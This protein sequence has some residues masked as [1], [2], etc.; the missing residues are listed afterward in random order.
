[1][2]FELPADLAGLTADELATLQAQAKEEF[3]AIY[4]A[5]GGPQADAL[6]RAG[7]LADALDA[8]TTE[9]TRRSEEAAATKAKFDEYAA[10]VNVQ[11]EGTEAEAEGEAAP[12]EPAAP[13][14]VGAG[15]TVASGGT[16]TA[17]RELGGLVGERAARINPSLSAAQNRVPAA[18][19]P[20]AELALTASFDMNRNGQVLTAGARIKDLDTLGALF[21]ERARQLPVTR[22]HRRPGQPYGGMAVAQL[23]NNFADSFDLSSPRD[24]VDKY[25][26]TLTKRLR[27]NE[28]AALTAAGGWC[29]PS[30][31]RYDF[32]SVACSGGRIDLPT[33]GVSRGGLRWPISPSLADAYS[34]D[35]APF[36]AEF[37]NATVPWLWTEGSDIMAATGSLTKPCIRIPCSSMDEARLECYGVCVTAGNLADNAWPESTRNFLRLLDAAFGHAVNSR[38]ISSIRSLTTDIGT[39]SCT[40]V[41]AISPLLDTAELAVWDYRERLGMCPDDVLE[42][43]LPAWAVGPMRQ[44]LGRRMGMAEFSVTDAMILQWFNVRGVRVQL[45][46]DYQVRSSGLPGYSTAITAWPSTVEFMIWS[47]GTFGLGNGM[48]LDLGVVRDSTLNA[49]ND[50]TAAW[51]EQCHLIAKFGHLARRYTVNICPSGTTGAA[52]MTTCCV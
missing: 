42:M 40:G 2:P 47:P 32:F 43:I 16:R 41:G 22:S 33:F 12:A 37:S 30:D 23:R 10:R 38:Y 24:A 26:E 13:E 36:E 27:P 46:D 7:Q 50:H 31:N 28:M 39:I 17:P 11:P 18:S 25:R 21:E 52:N 49:R 4:S 44:D 9:S 19:A 1:M 34:P 35:L 14:P 29:A 5:E 15:A 3:G 8:V 48:T 51:Y 20:G 45:V 6:E